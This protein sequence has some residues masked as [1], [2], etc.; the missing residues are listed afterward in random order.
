MMQSSTKQRGLI[1]SDED[2]IFR[3]YGIGNDKAFLELDPVEA[4]SRHLGTFADDNY[5]E[6]ITLTFYEENTDDED[7]L[8]PIENRSQG[9]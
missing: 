4:V 5:P 7:V 1:V 3:V 2:F 6:T 9:N 8:Y